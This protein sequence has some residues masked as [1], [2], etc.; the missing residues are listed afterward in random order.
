MLSVFPQAF[1]Y[2]VFAPLVLRVVLGIIFLAH[3]YPKL[4][5]K[6]IPG[7]SQYFASVGLKPGLF[8]AWVV[9]LLE[10][11]GG[12]FLIVGFLTQLAAAL[13]AIE[14]LVA[15]VVKRRQSLVGGFEFDFALFAIALS[16]VVLGAGA[17]AIDIP[18]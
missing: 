12:I 8:W 5:R 9:A 18:L 15:I 17:F 16:L 7:L 14:M 2:A 3:G 4:F 10:V 11:V 6:G 1:A 13:L